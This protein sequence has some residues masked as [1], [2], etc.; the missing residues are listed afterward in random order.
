MEKNYNNAYKSILP[1]LK[2]SLPLQRNNLIV[3]QVRKITPA[4]RYPSICYLTPIISTSR[5]IFKPMH[6]GKTSEECQSQCNSKTRILGCCRQL[7]EEV[8]LL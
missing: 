5:M 7:I 2:I 1:K 6:T 8:P 4:T 3:Y